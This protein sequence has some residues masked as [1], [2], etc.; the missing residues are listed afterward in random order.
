M[1]EGDYPVIGGGKNPSG[2]HNEYNTPENTILCSSSGAYA[3]YI[4]RYSTKVWASDCF[5][6]SSINE[7][8]VK[9]DYLFN[10]LKMKQ[11]DIYKL[12]SGAGQPHVYSKNIAS[13]IIPVPSIEIQEQI[14]A[15]MVKYSR[16]LQSLNSTIEL[17][18]ESISETID[19]INLNPSMERKRIEELFDF[20]CGKIGALKCSETGE[21]QVI[22]SS[23]V[24]THN[25][26]EL[27]GEN[28]F[29]LKVFDGAGNK[30]YVTKIK[31]FNGKC[32]PSSLI[33]HMIPKDSFSLKYVYYYL[34]H[35]VKYISEKYQKG[36]CNKSLDVDTFR[37][38]IVPIL[39]RAEQDSI[40]STIDL[41]YNA[42][43]SIKNTIASIDIEMKSFMDLL[44]KS[45]QNIGE[46]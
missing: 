8:I 21:Y 27:D 22:S 9:N 1:T 39:S 25:E 46:E 5:A 17:I 32:I 12:Q 26:Y 20:N 42:I 6:I 2:Y 38:F 4:S 31:F 11:D 41:K 13:L 36:A 7:S 40:V 16:T 28:L 23:D 14:V 43:E 24:H 10:F 44:F 3:G 37:N 34:Q 30:Q 15:K 35:N 29:I 45:S 19:N 33:Y 18:K